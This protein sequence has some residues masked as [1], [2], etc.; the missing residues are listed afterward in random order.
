MSKDEQANELL[1]GTW[2]ASS[3]KD[4]DNFEFMGGTV[5]KNSMYFR[6]DSGN[7]G[8]MDWDISTS[9]VNVTFEGNYQVR[10]D[11]TRLLFGE[12]Y[13]FILDVEKKELNITLLENTGNITFI[14]ERQ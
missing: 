6:Q 8:Y 13:E 2:K 1:A 4:K 9:L 10:D 12:D 14:A 7:L 11:G 5:T 3:I